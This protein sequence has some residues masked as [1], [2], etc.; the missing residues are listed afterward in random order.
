MRLFHDFQRDVRYAVAGLFRRPLFAGTAIATIGLGIGAATSVFNVINSLYLRTLPVPTA[1][2]L[3]R[4]EFHRPGGNPALGLA[5]VR[6]LRERAT[7]FDAVVA[8]D[9]RSVIQVRIG[10]RSVEQDGA[11]VSANYWTTLGLHPRLGRFFLPEEDSVVD[12]ANTDSG[13]SSS[14]PDRFDCYS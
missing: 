12:R 14:Y 11:F 5:A 10:T 3:I 9:S 1:D 13:R 6:I 2:R 4:V 8:H 7:A